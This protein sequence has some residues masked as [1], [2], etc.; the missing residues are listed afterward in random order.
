[1]QRV[2]D[3]GKDLQ[4]KCSATFGASIALSRERLFP[5]FSSSGSC[6]R[7]RIVRVLSRNVAE[8]G[9]S[10]SHVQYR[11][12]TALRMSSIVRGLLSLVFGQG[13]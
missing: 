12:I 3:I 8:T 10:V 11:S 6:D 4:G 7:P 9:G 5:A 2:S 1:M 13:T